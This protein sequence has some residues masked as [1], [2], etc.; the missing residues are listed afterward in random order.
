M[1]KTEHTPGPWFVNQAAANKGFARVTANN[2]MIAECGP[3]RE[4]NEQ[5]FANA[6]LIAAAP[7]LLETCKDILDD[8]K[9][10]RDIHLRDNKSVK[11]LK[12]AIAKAEKHD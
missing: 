10:G 7:D 9:C 3:H 2:G 6:H 5:H 4:A 8:I 1:S 11:C 12:A